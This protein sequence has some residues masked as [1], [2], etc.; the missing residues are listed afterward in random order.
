MTDKFISIEGITK[1]FPAPGGGTTTVFDNLWLSMSRGEFTCIIGHS[2]CGKTTVL[3]LLAGLDEPS[4][5]TIIVDNQSIEGPS[6]DRAVIFQSHALLPW[7]SVKGNVAYAVTSKW[8]RW[9]R[10]EIDAHAQKF[11][12]LV[13]LTGA[14]RK[15]PAELSGGMKQRVGIARALSIEPKIM[16]MDEPFSALDALTRGTLQDE[17]RRICLETGQTVFMITHDVDEAI[18][19][20][21]R[22]VLM[23]NGPNA[24]LAEI[25][26]NPLPK[27]RQRSDVHRHPLYYGVRNHVIDFLVTRSKS[28]N[29][30]LTATNYDPR[31]IPIVRPGAPEPVVAADSAAAL[32]ARPGL[33]AQAK[34]TASCG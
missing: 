20:A 33:P 18:Y 32:R 10:A 1:R 14:E 19:L 28:F 21:D 27:Q 26:E 6:L 3:N 13:G 8:R 34:L 7:L 17:V 9:R 15:R 23:T 31:H 25:V 4:A 5:G 12:D 29:E 30:G 22:I 16:L 2:G 24:V 11:I